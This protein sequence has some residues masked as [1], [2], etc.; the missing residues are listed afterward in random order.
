MLKKIFSMILIALFFP[1]LAGLVCLASN[2]QSEDGNF[3]KKLSVKE[4]AII[5]PKIA[6]KVL[7]A[8]QQ[9][10]A[11][12]LPNENILSDADVP[13]LGSESSEDETDRK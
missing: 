4:L 6:D 3:S 13:S 9:Q 8:D 11:K 10:E 12:Q 2:Q 7:N 1:I 5:T